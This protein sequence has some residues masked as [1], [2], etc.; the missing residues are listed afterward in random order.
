VRALLLQPVAQAFHYHVPIQ[1]VCVARRSAH[2]NTDVQ[3]PLSTIEVK[4]FKAS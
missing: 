1:V 2:G 3:V 4:R